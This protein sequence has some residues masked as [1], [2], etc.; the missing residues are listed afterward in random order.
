MSD[1]IELMQLKYEI[2]QKNVTLEKQRDFVDKWIYLNDRD[3][4]I[5]L[6]TL[7]AGNNYL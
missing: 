4:R 5:D 3:H 6:V 1:T 2:K 7:N